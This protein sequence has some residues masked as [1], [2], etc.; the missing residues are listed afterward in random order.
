MLDMKALA[1]ATATVVREILPALLKQ[2]TAPLLQR[3]AEL[4]AREPL[5][6]KD[7]KDVDIDELAAMINRAVAL[8]KI[9]AAQPGVD[10][11][12]VD[13]A[14]VRALVLAAVADL[15]PAEPGKD[16]DPELVRSLVAEAVAA[17][18]V[19]EPK[20]GNDGK[21]VDMD[22]VLALIVAAVADLPPP[23]AGKDADPELVR[24]LV[25]EAVAAIEIPAGKDGKDVD[26]EQVRALVQS[27][28]AALPPAPPGKDAD[29][30]LVRSLVADAV[31][32]IDLPQPRDGRDADPAAVKALVDEAVAALPPAAPGKSITAEDVAPLIREEIA[33][34]VADAVAALPLAKDG[35]GAAGAVIDRN[36]SLVLTLSD[37]KMVDLGRVDGKDGLDGTSPEDMAVELLPDGRTV[38][39]VFVKGEKEFA[40]QVPFPVVLD[41][42]VFK[43]GT[44]YEHGDAVTFGGSL[45]IAQRA[46]GEKPEG[47][48]TGWRLAVKKGR[49][50]RDLNKE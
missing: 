37:G 22:E 11:K 12:D 48:N 21:D 14:E 7:G 28:V 8:I 23:Q 41:R 42:G 16:A 44:A 29:P 27:A 1:Q 39:F 43:E 18:N 17:I 47:N 3:I 50:G 49:D 40:F 26:A 31:A 4:E 5:P 32:A 38:R 20:T 13:M 34:S 35:V 45:W 6:G 19:P 2:E 33:K 15:P 24:S 30:D 46:T 10:G 36:G 25:A 9:P